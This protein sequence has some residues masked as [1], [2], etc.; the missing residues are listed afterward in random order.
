MVGCPVAPSAERKS[1][2]IIIEDWCIGCGLC[3]KQCPYG[4][5]NMHP[6]EVQER[7]DP[8]NPRVMKGSDE[9]QGHHLRSLYGNTQRPACVAACPHEA[10]MRPSVPPPVFFA[11]Q[12][13][14][15]SEVFPQGASVC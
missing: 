10:A 1:L 7:S 5:I 9:A 4:N 11:E 13:D 6:F 12:A 14:R 8:Q 2:E 3:A 15:A